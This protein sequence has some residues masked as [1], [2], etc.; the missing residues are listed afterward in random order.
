MPYSSL[1][2]AHLIYMYYPGTTRYSNPLKQK[3][4]TKRMAAEGKLAPLFILLFD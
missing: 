1:T 2:C 3:F 4:R